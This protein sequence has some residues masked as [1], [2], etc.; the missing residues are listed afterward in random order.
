M[1][2]FLLTHDPEFTVTGVETKI[3]YQA[4]YD[5]YLEHL[6]KRTPWACTRTWEDD[7]LN[8]LDAPTRI[9][10]TLTSLPA[11]SAVV[12]VISSYHA[13][14]SVNHGQSTSATAQLQLGI[15]Q[16]MLDSG[17]VVEPTASATCGVS[18]H[19]PQVHTAASDM[20]EPE[21]VRHVTHHGGSKTVTSK[22]RGKG[23]AKC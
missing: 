16:L 10:S 4:D 9:T 11:S 19:Q 6:F 1:A 12:D 20:P 18:A 7:L 5:F 15:S 2:R 14:I 17:A 8:E 3:N 23:R 13:S 21:P 22:P